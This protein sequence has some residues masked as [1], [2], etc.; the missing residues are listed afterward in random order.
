MSY[1]AIFGV[2]IWIL[3]KFFLECHPERLVPQSIGEGGSEGSID[4]ESRYGGTQNDNRKKPQD[5]RIRFLFSTVFLSL[6]AAYLVQNLFIFDSFVSYLM[7]FFVLALIINNYQI[8]SSS[9]IP[10]LSVIPVQTGIQA[11]QKNSGSRIKCGMTT[12]IDI[13]KKLIFILFI[14]FILYSL[15]SYNLKPFL[16]ANYTNQILS[17]PASEAVQVAPLLKNVIALNSFASPEITYQVVLDYIDK[18]GQN[19]ALAQNEEFYN[20]ASGELSKIIERSPSQSRNYVALSWLNLYFSGQAKARIEQSWPLAQKVRELSPSKKDAYLLLVA[21]YALS[22]QPQKAL[23]V[24]DQAL[25]VDAKMGEEVKAYLE[26][27]K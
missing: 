18:I 20:V 2:S 9:V 25:V 22:N 1:L 21:G 4:S 12:K 27:L 10:A 16:A 15:F 3:V 19:P 26:R 8:S 14:F 13:V 11:N 5:D 23:E 7:L 17:L 6:L 24:V